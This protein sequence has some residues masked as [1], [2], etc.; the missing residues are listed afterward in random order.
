MAKE[1]LILLEMGRPM[2]SSEES[3]KANKKKSV[4]K[5][6]TKKTGKKK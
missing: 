5:K 3:K 6:S 1:D 2:P 4:K